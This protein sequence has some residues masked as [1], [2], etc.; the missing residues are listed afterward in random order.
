MGYDLYGFPEP[1]GHDSSSPGDYGSVCSTE[2]TITIDLFLF[3]VDE[4]K[5]IRDLTLHVGVVIVGWDG[6]PVI[7]VFMV[8]TPA[9]DGQ[10]EGEDG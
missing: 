1:R 9:A 4:S 8:V 5:M 6:Y 3:G 2:L 7:T 10:N